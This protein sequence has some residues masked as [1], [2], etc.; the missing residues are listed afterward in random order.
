MY[1]LVL[2]LHVLTAIF[3]IGPLVH[4]ATTAARGLRSGDAALTAS[5][6]RSAKIY[7]NV[8]LVVVILGFALMSMERPYG[9]KGGEISQ[10]WIWVSAI[11]WLVATGLALGVVVPT[12]E[13]ATATIGGGGQAGTEAGKVG[14]VGGVIALCFAVIVFLMVYQPGA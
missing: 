2:A 10:P 12:L 9:G 14:A 5:S 7:A 4:I 1:N 11:L 8:S 13:K 6:A 3:A